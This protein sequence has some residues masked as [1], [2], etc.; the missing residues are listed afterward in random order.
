MLRIDPENMSN[1]SLCLAVLNGALRFTV[2]VRLPTHAN[3]SKRIETYPTPPIPKSAA[4]RGP[5][6]S[7]KNSSN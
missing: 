6:D 3:S 4:R 5:V 2:P 7:L 1:L